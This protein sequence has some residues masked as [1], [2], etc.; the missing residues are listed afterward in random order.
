METRLNGEFTLPVWFHISKLTQEHQ[1]TRE[2]Q[3]PQSLCSCLGTAFQLEKTFNQVQHS[4]TALV[5][6]R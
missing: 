4:W 6:G 3:H 1:H 2:K 5:A